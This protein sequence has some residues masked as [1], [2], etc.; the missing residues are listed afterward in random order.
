MR[1]HY[2]YQ[3][4][5]VTL[6]YISVYIHRRYEPGDSVRKGDGHTRHGS[7]GG[8]SAGVPVGKAG[9]FPGVG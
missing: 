1:R 9:G 4:Q 6:V 8:A 7:G 3:G 2:R 5:N